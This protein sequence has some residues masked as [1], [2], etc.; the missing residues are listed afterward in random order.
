[1][2]GEGNKRGKMKG[3]RT[4]GKKESRETKH[5]GVRQRIKGERRGNDTKKEGGQ[6]SRG[7][8]R[9]SRWGLG[10]REL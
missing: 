3:M 6:G 1:M 4:E 8:G 5:N 10:D 2:I 9:E 7:E